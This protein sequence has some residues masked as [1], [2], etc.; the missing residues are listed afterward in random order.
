MDAADGNSLAAIGF[1]TALQDTAHGWFGGYLVL[2]QLGRPLEFHCTTPIQPTRAQQILYGPTLRSY[3]L[4]EIIGHTLVNQAELPVGAVLTDL[5]EMLSLSLLQPTAVACVERVMDPARLTRGGAQ[6]DVTGSCV[7][8]R[9]AQREP[10]KSVL[11][12]EIGHL[13]LHGTSTCHWEPEQLQGQ[14][15]PLVEHIDLLEPFSRIREAILEAQ[16]ISADPDE[17]PFAARVAA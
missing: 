7:R 16:R 12:L 11:S 14:L 15:M 5:P 3:L 2:S 1:L 8:P 13:Q 6:A 4:G 17:G 10:D 9:I